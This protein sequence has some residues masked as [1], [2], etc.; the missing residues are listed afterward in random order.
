MNPLILG[1]GLDIGKQLINR[2][3]GSK[4]EAKAKEAELELMLLKGELTAL[5]TVADIVKTEAKSEHWITAAWR[6]LVMLT[7][8]GLIVAK[9]L[10]YT[11]PGISAEMELELMSIIKIGLGGYVVGRSAEKIVKE[12][13]K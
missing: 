10:G 7:F 11:A 9:W 12:Y 3:F 13:K 8:T 1:A 6:P 5:D 2:W 4:D